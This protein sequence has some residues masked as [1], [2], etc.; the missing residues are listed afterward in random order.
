M[1]YRR[2]TSID[3]PYF[4]Q[5]HSLMQAIFPAEEV[6]EAPLWAEPLQDQSLRVC[7]AVHDGEVV[8]A[9]EYRYLAQLRVAMAD[10][11]IIGRSGLGVGPFL[12]RHREAD[13]AQMVAQ[14]GTHMIGMF[15]EI[16]DPSKAATLDFGAFPLMHPVVRREVL[17]HLGFQRLD[18]PYLHPSWLNDGESVSVLDLC[19]RPT[20]ETMT[21]LPS[22]LVVDFLTT[23]Y[24]I[25]PNKPEAWHQ[26][27]D[28][29]GAMGTIPLRP[30]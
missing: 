27:I 28:R 3:D 15:A 5:M 4:G 24:A 21:A 23:Y 7:V 9:T 14:S 17:S 20:D 8:G 22:Q 25:L 18:F 16:Y 6:L 26:M 29:I 10:F 11:T 12:W 2:I 1:E 13:L 19:F 30:L